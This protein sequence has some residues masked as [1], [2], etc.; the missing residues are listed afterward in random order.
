MKLFL[1]V[2]RQSKQSGAQTATSA[3][4]TRDWVARLPLLDTRESLQQIHES[5]HGLNRS[6]LKTAQRLKLLDMHRSPLRVIL[7]QVESRFSRGAAPLSQSDLVV[8]GLFRDCCVEMAF[9]YKILVLET[10][11]SMK[12]R[13][14]DEMKISMA[15]ALFYLEQTVFA[16][17]LFRH[18]PP[19]GI[20][21]EVHTLYSYARKLGVAEESLRDPVSKVRT[22]TNIS[23]TYR[24]ALLFGLSDPFHQSVPLMR[25]VVDFLRRRAGNAQLKR[26]IRTPRGHCQ[27]VIDPQS[28]YP[29][30]PYLKSDKESPPKNALFLDTLN[31]TRDARELLKRLESA[32][33][34]DVEL[35]SEFKDELG[36]KLLR[37]VVYKWG[38][39][40]T[41]EEERS[42]TDNLV[43]IV[44]G[45]EAASYYVN[46]ESPF[47][48]S[49]VDPGDDDIDTLQP[50]SSDLRKLECR[51]LDRGDTG[52]RITIPYDAAD[53]GALR[54]GSVITCREA[55]GSW[56][57]GLIRWIR[58]IDESIHLGVQKLSDHARPVA[59]KPVSNEREDPFKAALAI[60][61][62]HDDG[63]VLR[64]ITRPGLYR[65]QRN[66]FVDDGQALLMVRIRKL[67]ESSQI[68]EW[69]ECETL[70]L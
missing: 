52:L 53:A 57:P 30:K 63:S 24:R 64:L 34:I 28:D 5:L 36:K 29:A 45:I 69:F 65:P 11:R 68:M 22:S 49:S 40:L 4:R 62:K 12:R 61:A 60:R 26:N 54:V 17:A 35:D 37:E 31:L 59:V 1:A 13:Q 43:E 58:C 44:L 51:V 33:Q 66:L 70:N 48:L 27:F 23:L 10:A 47:S 56:S 67:I 25:R 38:L 41:R 3:G 46:G 2:P 18:S 16:C 15:R 9:G 20:W 14:L 19:E 50:R 32:E 6:L 39:I 55:D 8:A 21:Q 42:A 7:G